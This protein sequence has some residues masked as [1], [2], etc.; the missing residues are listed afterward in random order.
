MLSIYVFMYV[1]SQCIPQ[2]PKPPHKPVLKPQ[3]TSPSPTT[4]T[5]LSNPKATYTTPPIMPQENTVLLKALFMQE[6]HKNETR[7]LSAVH[8]DDVNEAVRETTAQNGSRNESVGSSPSLSPDAA[9]VS[10][11]NKN[12]VGKTDG[13]VEDARVEP[14]RV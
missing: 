14:A 13:R 8:L 12:V 6:E 5:S 2:R 11:P 10:L 9:K 4:Y 1:E 3:S 7:R